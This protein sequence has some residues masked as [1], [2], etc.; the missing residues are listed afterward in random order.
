MRI[1]AA[2]QKKGFPN[3]SHLAR[4]LEVA[5]KTV[6]R[7]LE[8]MRDRMGLP[9]EFNATRNGYQY[10]EE[11]DGFPSLQIS[12]GELFALMVAEKALQQYRGTPFEHRLVSALRKLERALPDTVSLN[13]ADWDHAISFRT[14][15]E[16]IVNI[17]V[18]ER[19]ADAIQR[20]HQLEITYRKPGTRTADLRVVDPYHLANV[21]GDWYLFAFDHLRQAIRTFAPTRILSAEPTG[22]PFIRPA[23]FALEKQLR[24]SFGVHSKEGD[25]QV[26]LRFDE[27]VSDYIR[28]KRWHPSQQIE[29]LATGGIEL[30]LRLGSLVEIQRWILGWAGHARVLAPPELI[31][32]VR[33]AARELLAVHPP[34][35][36]TA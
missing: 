34:A 26:I 10:T 6:H 30:R 18:L 8:F 17:P 36:D 2:L 33:T 23:R 32:G 5:T 11:V 4:E 15:A 9:I 14:S 19:L 1:H 25:F 22:K 20:R 12:E 35:A 29:E 7:D 21:N 24:D 16:P 31:V 28:E 3:A 27:A 13:L